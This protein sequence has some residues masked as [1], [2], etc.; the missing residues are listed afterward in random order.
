MKRVVADVD[1]NEMMRSATK[2]V[3]GGMYKQYNASACKSQSELFY[4]FCT[5]NAGCEQAVEIA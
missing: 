5:V 1:G 4:T 2:C 3:K